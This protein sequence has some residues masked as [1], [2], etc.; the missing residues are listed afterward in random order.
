MVG[1]TNN[2]TTHSS[3]TLSMCLNNGKYHYLC[4]HVFNFFELFRQD[5]S[6]L[7]NHCQKVPIKFLFDGQSFVINENQKQCY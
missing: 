6:D 3:V 7:S 5:L 4:G 1:Y 2:Y